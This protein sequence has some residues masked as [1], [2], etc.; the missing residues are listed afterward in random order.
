[1]PSRPM[2]PEPP[3]RVPS[4]A[5]G[6]RHPAASHPIERGEHPSGL[7][8]IASKIAPELEGRSVFT[9]VRLV[10]WLDQQ[11]N[12]RVIL[13]SAEAGYGKPPL[14]GDYARRSPGRVDL[15]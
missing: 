3:T 15:P 6:Y 5:L 7:A 1:M 8:I 2:T 11:K 14:P 9:R 12:A 10:G 4:A 13:V